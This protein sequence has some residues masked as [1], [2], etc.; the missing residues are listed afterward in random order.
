MLSGSPASPRGNGFRARSRPDDRSAYNRVTIRG[1]FVMG[2]WSQHEHKLPHRPR[3]QIMQQGDAQT[4]RIT[5]SPDFPLYH[6]ITT[7]TQATP[8]PAL[9][10]LSRPT[11]SESVALGLTPSTKNKNRWYIQAI[12]FPSGMWDAENRRS[13]RATVIPISPIAPTPKARTSS[14]VDSPDHPLCS[15]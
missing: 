12:A 6:G 5:T 14:D 13:L 8:L 7:P 15:S 3:R 11:E 1:E 2:P 9:A 4:L 10:R